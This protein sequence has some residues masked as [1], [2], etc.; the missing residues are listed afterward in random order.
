L[1][2]HSLCNPGSNV[3]KSLGAHLPLL[4]RF[5][6]RGCS[7]NLCPPCDLSSTHFCSG[8]STHLPLLLGGF[9]WLGRSGY[10]AAQKLTEFLLQRLD[11]LLEVGCL[12]ELLRCCVYHSAGVWM[13]WEW[14]S[15][16]RCYGQHRLLAL[17]ILLQ[18]ANLGRLGPH[19]L[20]SRLLHHLVINEPFAKVPDL[21]VAVSGLPEL[22]FCASS[23]MF[24]GFF[25]ERDRG[26][27]H[28][29]GKRCP[30]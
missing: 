17:Q 19:C 1:C 30:S 9:S 7:L 24:W 14:R 28:P 4:C 16:W 29:G 20:S 27:I 12:T 8:G 15:S 13:D 25:I 6:C 3:G 2:R 11:L 21:N 10:F 26:L 22:P 5:S 18:C 23:G